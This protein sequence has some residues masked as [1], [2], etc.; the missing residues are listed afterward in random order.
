LLPAPE[1]AAAPASWASLA[2]VDDVTALAAR[3]T[4]PPVAVL[5]ATTGDGEDPLG[6][7]TRVAAVVQAWLAAAPALDAVPLV[8]V[9]R[10]AVPATGDADVTDPAG[11]AVWGL[12]RRWCRDQD[13][14]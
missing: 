7:T 11:A 9:T 5:T 10:G 3:E 2:G 12:I 1:G 6:L 8:V 14:D 13:Q 4:R